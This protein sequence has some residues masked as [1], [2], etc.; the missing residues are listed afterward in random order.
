MVRHVFC[1]K[2]NS[3]DCWLCGEPPA[4]LIHHEYDETCPDCGNKLIEHS[5]EHPCPNPP[6][7]EPDL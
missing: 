3:P 2:F 5:P 6:Y 7:Q 4:D 1:P